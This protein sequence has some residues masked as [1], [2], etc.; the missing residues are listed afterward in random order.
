MIGS[1]E[2]DSVTPAAL[3]L[4]ASLVRLAEAVGELRQAQ[5]HAAQAAAARQAA[6]R[7]YAAFGRAKADAAALRLASQA[8]QAGDLPKPGDA[9]R[10]DF[11]VPARRRTARD[12]GR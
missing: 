7:L 10:L 4:A 6:E 5:Q 8:R 2:G 1:G 12:W 3:A 11:P 9:A